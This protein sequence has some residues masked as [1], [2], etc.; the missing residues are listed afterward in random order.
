MRN[1]T[2]INM[3][4]KFMERT[5]SQIISLIVSIVLARILLPDDYGIISMVTVF[6]VFA[7]VLVTSGLPTALIQKKDIDE[8][9]FSTVFYANCLV[10]IVLYFVLF[11]SSNLISEYFKMPELSAVLKVLGIKVIISSINSVQ[12][13]YLS[14]KMLFRKYFSA[15]FSGTICSGVIG[16]IMAKNGAGVWALVVQQLVSA[17]VCV[18]VLFVIVKWH[19]RK[20]FSWKKLK[21]LFAFGWKI[22]FEGISET[23]TVQVRNL[24]IGKVYTSNDLA[25]YTKAQQFPNLLVSNVS[26]SVSSVLFPVMSSVQE[27]E[28]QVKQLMRKAVVLT[29]YIMFPL[30]TGLAL[31]AT[32]FVEVVLTDKWIECVPYLQIFCFTQVTTVGMIARHEALKSIGRSDVFM[33]E[34]MVYR[35]ISLSLLAAVYKISVLAIALSLIGGTVVMSITVGIT[36]KKY[37]NYGYKEQLFDVLPIM[38]ACFGMAIPVYCFGIMQVSPLATL[39]LQVLVGGI[40]YLVLSHILKLEGYLF[41]LEQLKIFVRKEKKSA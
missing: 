31:V 6:T 19:P 10:G 4:W 28:E 5:V 8:T 41:I 22:L 11:F 23:F 39:V 30:A 33:Y 14:R 34:H 36:S 13:A 26:S 40:S 20:L 35:I 2:I 18:I 25:F 29:S 27:N 3:I 12:F 38:I 24:L 21:V 7:D 32:P 37:N 1:E 9:D 17:C 16:I 15:T